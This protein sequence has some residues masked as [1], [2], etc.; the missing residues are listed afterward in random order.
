[1]CLNEK[2]WF[3]SGITIIINTLPH[4]AWAYRI[5]PDF[6]HKNSNARNFI[7]YLHWF[8]ERTD[9]LKIV[10]LGSVQAR[11][12]R[13]IVDEHSP[14]RCSYIARFSFSFQQSDGFI[15]AISELSNVDYFSPES[16]YGICDFVLG[17]DLSFRMIVQFSRY[18]P[19]QAELGFPR[20]NPNQIIHSSEK[21]FLIDT[22]ESLSQLQR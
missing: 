20:D 17:T 12:E 5:N 15:G 6:P 19:K 1:L 22:P 4:L 9:K 7:H 14:T 21:T 8:L 16:G 2:T 10:F 11:K 3:N 13:S 18:H